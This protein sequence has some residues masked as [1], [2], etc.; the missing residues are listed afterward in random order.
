[1][2]RFIRKGSL[3]LLLA[4]ALIALGTWA[5]L[6]YLTHR[7]STSAFVNTEL[8]RLTAPIP[9]R[10]ATGLPPK[11]QFLAMPMH[12]ALIE[13]TAPDRRHLAGL[14]Q[15]RAVAE[16]RA[17]L[18]AQQI[19]EIEEAARGLGERGRQHRTATLRR[20]QAEL[21][22]AEADHIACMTE[23]EERRSH[24]ARMETLARNG[25]APLSRLEE[26]RARHDGVFARCMA[27][28]ARVA[29][30]RGEQ[31]AARQGIFLRDGF[32]DAPYSEQ[33][34]D[35]LQLRRQELEGEH[36]RE[37]TRAAQ[38][39]QEITEERQRL[40]R[41]SHYEAVLPAGHVVWSIAASPGTSVVEGQTILDVANCAERFVVVELPERD[42]ESI[43]AG[44]E[45]AVRLL[46]GG[47]W[48]RGEVLRVRGSAARSDERL[49][50]AQVPNPSPRH[51]SVEVSLPEI[52]PSEIGEGYCLIGRLA[53]VRFRRGAG[54]LAWLGDMIGTS[55]GTA[56][57]AARSAGLGR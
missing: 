32:N 15:E 9:G 27:A 6:P 2:E 31:V 54:L 50:A 19:R 20:L 14:E 42:F 37:E 51:I 52:A 3:R 39:A 23:E 1:M 47:A 33:Q 26:A 10:V 48:M 25:H 28:D 16:A 21:E 4:L 49:L 55:R 46:G 45:A 12:I 36:L 43:Q 56:N 41:V 44:T 35:R 18:L 38:L 57:Q 22:E 30:L 53:E 34:R 11:G 7:V 40:E 5:F 24:R 29:R 13:A 8:V 17:R